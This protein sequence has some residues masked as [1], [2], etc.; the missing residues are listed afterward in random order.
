[1]IKNKKFN[2]ML[3]LIVQII[4]VLSSMIYSTVSVFGV[5]YEE[6]KGVYSKGISDGKI[7]FID[8]DIE[9]PIPDPTDP[10]IPIDPISP[11]NP[12]K[13]DLRIMYVSNFNFNQRKLLS[14]RASVYHAE[15]V[16]VKTIGNNIVSPKYYMGRDKAGKDQNGQPVDSS[17]FGDLSTK[18][19]RET[20]PFITTMDKRPINYFGRGGWNLKVSATVFQQGK[21][22]SIS[23]LPGADIK[24]ANLFYANQNPIK[25][26]YITDSA[27]SK[28][29]FMKLEMGMDA[30]SYNEQLVKVN[31]ALSIPNDI[32]NPVVVASATSTDMM[33]DPYNYRGEGPHTLALGDNLF[34][35]Y[36]DISEDMLRKGEKA[37]KFLS[38]NGVML[39]IPQNITPKFG[40]TNE[41][42]NRDLK[43]DSVDRGHE[44]E[45]AAFYR[46]KITWV[47]EPVIVET[48]PT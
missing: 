20:V 14:N 17:L 9:E 45:P 40:K 10:K 11:I 5:E 4:I 37:D 32:K 16:L 41:H 39:Y 22:S 25:D 15:S 47:L 3:V 27:K 19:I 42:V 7:R 6:L 21:G 31:S 13:S 1:M 33:Q 18:E 35:D 29:P 34:P 26:A 44:E 2:H 43:N 8:Q 24:L 30:S 38:T 36:N 46:T 28:V 23:L 48:V 12:G